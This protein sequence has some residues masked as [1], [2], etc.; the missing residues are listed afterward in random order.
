MSNN[1]S[2][3]QKI[4]PGAAAG[5]VATWPMTIFM[6]YIWRRLP[7]RDRQP[8]PP[9]QITGEVLEDVGL[10]RQLSGRTKTALTLLLHFS[11]GAL[12][13]SMYGM[14]EGRIPLRNSVKGALAGLAVWTG[15]YLGWIPALGILPPA[16]Q[17]SWRRNLLMIV[18]HLVWGV[19]LSM[20]LR[21]HNSRKVYI[22]LQ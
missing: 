10:R 1:N 22:D 19:S 15:S 13:G 7:A 21:G 17:H 6:L 5:W 14:L 12:A 8:L 2:P 18:A 11:F 16:T 9:R 4:I 3:M 20:L